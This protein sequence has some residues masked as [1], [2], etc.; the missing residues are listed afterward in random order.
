M[1]KPFIS[2][3]NRKKRY[4][5]CNARKH[6]ENEWGKIIYSDESRFELFQND[7]NDWVWRSSTEK[8]DKKY[9]R[10]TVKKSDG[11]MVWDVFQKKK[12]VHWCLLRVN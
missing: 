8:Y 3:I 10:P 11:I 1:K 5:W 6:W 4:G 12:L 7:S 9:L 2:E